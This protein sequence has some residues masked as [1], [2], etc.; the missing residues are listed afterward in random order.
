MKHTI[1]LTS[2]QTSEVVAYGGP[3]EDGESIYF[4]SGDLEVAR[5]KKEY[6][7]GLSTCDERS[8]PKFLTPSE[9]VEWIKAAFSHDSATLDRLLDKQNARESSAYLAPVR[10]AGWGG[11]E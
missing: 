9:G 7:A 10:F 8:D 5:F 6:I 4:K 1:Y 2:G 3:I 11:M